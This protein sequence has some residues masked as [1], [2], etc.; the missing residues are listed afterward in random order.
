MARQKNRLAEG[1]IVDRQRTLRFSFDGKTYEGHPGDTLASALLA[2][3][4]SQM[5]WWARC[6]AV[7]ASAAASRR[8]KPMALNP[9]GMDT[10][11]AATSIWMP[12][13]RKQAAVLIM[14]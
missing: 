9:R 4:L 10:S 13:A 2:N 6:G 7:V 14:C 11:H 5:G 3:R 1:G 8:S 12:K